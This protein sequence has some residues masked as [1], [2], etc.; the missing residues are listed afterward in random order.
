M[1][2]S[3][4]N[5]IEDIKL[6]LKQY[7]V[8]LVLGLAA[9]ILIAGYFLVLRAPLDIYFKNATLL[10]DLNKQVNAAKME[11]ADAQDYS[12]KLYQPTTEEK[13]WLDMSLPDQPDFSSLIEHIN[14]LTRRAGFTIAN[15]DIEES[16]GRS[17]NVSQDNIGKISV[18]LKLTG[19]GYEELKRFVSLT[20]SSIM[21]IDI[22][23]I[24]FSAK[25]TTYDLSLVVYYYRQ[26]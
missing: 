5:M 12:A 14:G 7:Q 8:F 20:E 26:Q 3:S 18:R 25:D 21:M 17:A 2:G 23:S 24:N 1:A 13:R 6:R 11:L 15:I 16:N 9:I 4:N 10:S 22:S 19:G